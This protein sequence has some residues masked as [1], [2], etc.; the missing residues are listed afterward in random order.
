[1]GVC[2]RW[3]PSNCQVAAVYDWAGSMTPDI[4]DFK[5]CDPLGTPLPPSGELEDRFTMVMATA[6]HTPSLSESDDEIQFMGFGAASNSNMNTTLPDCEPN[7]E[8]TEINT[9]A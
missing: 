2:S 1:M 4:V 6:T 3:F 7:V 9:D 8:G 5:L